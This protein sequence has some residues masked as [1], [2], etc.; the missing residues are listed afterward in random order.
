MEGRSMEPEELGRL[1]ASG[2]RRHFEPYRRV[3]LVWGVVAPAAGFGATLMALFGAERW[4]PAVWI[5]LAA[6]GVAISMTASRRIERRTGVRP[7]L[8]GYLAA[9]WVGGTACIVALAL[10]GALG[11]V[12]GLEYLPAL[13]LPV[14]ALC[15]LVSGSLFR[16]R[17][18]YAASACLLLGA[19]PAAAF[20]AAGSLIQGG[21]IGAV[22]IAIGARRRG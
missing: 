20:P 18:L 22:S 5:A 14:I 3:F 19:V 17:W 7:A 13:S 12:F 8:L 2:S 6:V 4:I 10:I 16:S 11:K 1:L 21:L 15:A 9:L